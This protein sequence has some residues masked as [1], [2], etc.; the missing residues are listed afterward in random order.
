MPLSHRKSHRDNNSDL[1]RARSLLKAY[2]Y[3]L[4]N[5]FQQH[6]HYK[7]TSGDANANLKDLKKLANVSGGK[8][9]SKEQPAEENKAV[10]DAG[11]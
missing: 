8:K 11:K 10:H 1:N 6:L 7:P 3:L 5:L 9:K 4:T 2:V